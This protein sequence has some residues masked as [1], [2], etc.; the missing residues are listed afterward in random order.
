[1]QAGA[2]YFLDKSV[3]FNKVRDVIASL[4]AVH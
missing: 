3:E 4:G 2:S 1:M